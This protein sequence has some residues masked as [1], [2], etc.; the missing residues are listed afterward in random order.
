MHAKN[1][2]T[3]KITNIVFMGMGE[4]FLNIPSMEKTIDLLTHPKCLALSPSKIAISTAG[5]GPGIADFINKTQVR[6]AVSIHFTTNELRSKYMPVNKKFPLEELLAELKH[7]KLK[8]RDFIS[9]EYIMFD[10][11]NDSL[12]HA[13][14]LVKLLHG[15][16]VKLNLIPYNPTDTLDEKASDEATI[17][18]FAQYFRDRG[19]FASVRYSKGV[20]VEG[21]CGQ[22]A[23][24]TQKQK[25]KIGLNPTVVGFNRP[26]FGKIRSPRKLFRRKQAS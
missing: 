13:K 22:F 9:I 20:D 21:G 11:I 5:I 8:K 15:L 24:K 16:K 25:T 17:R 26:T 2:I 10:G 4:P 7:I 14:R 3:Q 12:V 1:D 19:I 6:L 18:T 23:H